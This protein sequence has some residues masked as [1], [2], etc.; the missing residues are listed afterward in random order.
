MAVQPNATS[1]AFCGWVLS[2]PWLKATNPQKVFIQEVKDAADAQTPVSD[3]VW[4]EFLRTTGLWFQY[5][6]AY[7]EQ[8]G[9]HAA[10]P[11]NIVQG[12]LIY[13]TANNVLSR[14]PK[15]AV[16]N[17]FLRNSGTANNPAWSQVDTSL[18][19]DVG[20]WTDYSS[21]S[22]VIGFSAYTVKVIRY[23]KIN[24]STYLVS[25][26]M[27]GTSNST[28]LTFT[29]PFIAKNV[30][31]YNQSSVGF[32]RDNGIWNFVMQQILPNASLVTCYYG[33]AAAAWTAAGTKHTTG[34]MF[35]EV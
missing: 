27:V 15:S 26:Q 7:T 28:A 2:T 16:A 20:I 5:Y 8:V 18:L 34:Q 4:N 31:G 19:S 24:A 11:Q 21:I 29:L 35:I 32:G 3:H 33:P 10:I 9:Q 22:T 6:T 12:D 25:W 30:T 23:K 13:G 14:L 1:S 17:S